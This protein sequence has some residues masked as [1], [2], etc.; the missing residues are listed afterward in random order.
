M[1]ENT[2]FTVI[3]I[4][5]RQD[6]SGIF[7]VDSKDVAGLHLSGASLPKLCAQIEPAIK[8]LYRLNKGIE[9]ISLRP[10]S[11]AAHFPADP[12][13]AFIT[14]TACPSRYVAYAHA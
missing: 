8:L 3:E 13:P 4:A 9:D 5:I 10:V 11:E 6:A 14:G 12:V 2:I 1:P 7:H